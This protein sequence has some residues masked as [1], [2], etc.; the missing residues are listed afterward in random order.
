MQNP[1]L[2]NELPGK[3]R[4]HRSGKH[5]PASNIGHSNRDVTIEAQSN[6]DCASTSTSQSH[7]EV[8]P[9]TVADVAR[10]A[11]KR[12]NPAAISFENKDFPSSLSY[13]AKYRKVSQ[14]IPWQTILSSHVSDLSN[15]SSKSKLPFCGKN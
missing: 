5:Y 4:A 11:G 12:N 15:G 1:N 13:L 14:G 8:E 7:G 6:G 9:P 10:S 2:Y 3:K